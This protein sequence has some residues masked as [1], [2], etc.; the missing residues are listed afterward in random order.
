MTVDPKIDHYKT[1]GVN[2][3]ASAEQIKKAYRK[4]AKQY[5]PDSTGGCKTRE[6]RFKEIS[7]AY[8]V[9]G[10]SDKRRQYDA[11]RAGG[12]PPGFDGFAGSSAFGGMGGLGDF[13]SL[14]SQV[15]SG[16]TGNSQ[17]EFRFSGGASPFH[18]SGRPTQAQR[19]RKSKQATKK[20]RASDGSLVD[21]RGLDI[22]SDLRLTIDQAILGC[23][24]SL[25]TVDGTA[26]VRVPPGTSSGAKLRLKG[27][28]ARGRDGR[29]GSHYA[30]VHIDVPKQLNK[31]SEE[32]LA[33]FMRSVAR[34]EA[35][36]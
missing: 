23:I 17:V 2:P 16:G 13:G 18:T 6:G 35:K 7:T 22:H 14:F 9:L 30:T 26:K 31:K 28:G 36:E 20:Q 19:K 4:L 24:V 33:K 1:L 27:K 29:V 10:D 12:M 34:T 32:L 8:D 15:F 21:Q 11:M 25:A 5:H 3:D